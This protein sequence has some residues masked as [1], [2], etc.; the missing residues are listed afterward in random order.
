MSGFSTVVGFMF[1]FVILIITFS[2]AM[3]M[4]NDQIIEQSEILK[5]SEKDPIKNL[6]YDFS[7]SNPYYVSGRI[8][9]LL[10][11]TGSEDLI[12]RDIGTRDSCFTFIDRNTFVSDEDIFISILNKSLIYNYSILEESDMASFSA[13]FVYD[14]TNSY[15]SKIISCDGVEKFVSFD[16]S[17]IDW[18]SNNWSD[19]TTIKINNSQS[20]LF[21]YQVDVTFNASNF[22]FSN[23]GKEELR[24]LLPLKE[25]LVYDVTLDKYGQQL[26]DY[27]DFNIV[28]YLGTNV[29]SEVSDPTSREGV[30]GKGLYFDG[31]DDQVFVD[32]TDSN[33]KGVDLSES[34]T[35]SLWI[36]WNGSGNTIQGIISDDLTTS[37]GLSIVNDG[38]VN[39]DKL[40][41]TINS[42]TTGS[43][44]IYSPD[45]IS[46][47]W[48]HVG[49][50]YDGS[51]MKLYLDGVQVSNTT[52]SGLVN[53]SY[54]NTY[55]GT[56]GP[57]SYFSGYMDEIKIFH[58]ALK[59]DEINDLYNNNL[60]FRELDYYI[61]VW[62]TSLSYG[63]VHIKMP[64][65]P[66]NQSVS[67]QM[68]Y[69]NLINPSLTDNSDIFSVYTYDMPKTIGYPVLDYYATGGIDITSLF[70]DNS[71]FVGSSTYS[72]DKR[73]NVSISS[74]IVDVNTSIGLKY[75]SQVEGIGNSADMIVPVSWAGKE[76][77]Y[78]GF[79][80]GTDTICM[81]SPWG[82]AN[83][84]IFNDSASLY[85]GTVDMGGDCVSLGI[86]TTASFGL[87]SDIPI[88]A[89][90]R[91]G[92]N[93]VFA[94]YPATEE[95]IYGIPSNSLYLGTGS[96][97]ANITVFESDGTT[98]SSDLSSYQIYSAGGNGADGASPAFRI[99]STDPIGAIQQADTDGSESTVFVPEKEF[100]TIFGSLNDMQYVVAL[101]RYSDANC[102]L[103]DSLGNLNVSI[104]IGSGGGNGLYTY[105]VDVGNDVF[106]IDGP[107]TFECEKPVWLYYEKDSP[108]TDET[109]LMS[110]KQMRQYVYPSPSITIG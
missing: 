52:K 10:E 12:F 108:D 22:N 60:R 16:S 45:V 59:S 31:S 46:N 100:G 56:N 3:Y 27:S 33:N 84:E 98:S 39:D 66:E 63:N 70:D 2:G 49:A 57:G 54:S 82:T 67:V 64:I 43:T 36:K 7:F 71:V 103:Y 37:T 14:E 109:N 20:T 83:V 21:D 74:A 40:S 15:E 87:L 73:E 61:N 79:R 92:G 26:I 69:N 47:G 48:H 104:P 99:T 50:T 106:Y 81:L 1:S 41:F 5:A 29:N 51:Y 78:S 80:G 4:Y 93:D 32:F 102:S 25:L 101:S 17:T 107:W 8:N 42:L 94:M 6:N 85:T 23:I 34:L 91:G 95:D 28:S 19:R 38:G 44:T 9:F 30:I 35:Y 75:P 65:L 62:D 105:S 88:L 89:S 72:L 13:N 18:W 97:G 76:F 68:Y 86:D 58:T 53:Y 90:Y 110:F 96:S 77:Y 55:I 11:N 24:F